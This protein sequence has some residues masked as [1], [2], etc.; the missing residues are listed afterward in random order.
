M[1]IQRPEE[2]EGK[3]IEI[4]TENATLAGTII[5]V[6]HGNV[7]IEVSPKIYIEIAMGSVY[8]EQEGRFLYRILRKQ[9][10]GSVKIDET[11]VEGQMM[12]VGGDRISHPVKKIK[13]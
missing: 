7:T 11:P 4:Q 9:P 6:L 8:A 2:L 5:N 13:F 1:T 10:D 12:L 3:P